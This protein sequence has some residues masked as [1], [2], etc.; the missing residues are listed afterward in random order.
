MVKTPL[1]MKEMQVRFPGEG[2]GNPLQYS[3]L[4]NPM[5]RSLG[6]YSPWG[7]KRSDTTEGLNNNKRDVFP[8]SL[9]SQ[10]V[11]VVK[12]LPAY[13]GYTGDT[14]LIPGLGRSLGEGH[15]NPLQYSCLENPIDR[16]AWWATVHGI[17]KSRTQ[18]KQLNMH[19]EKKILSERQLANVL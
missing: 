14:G 6:D 10:F 19:K 7:H 13:T 2:S 4:G 12:N 11:L 5:D 3:C 18:L 16:G 8:L 9:G 1:A 17:A 15:G